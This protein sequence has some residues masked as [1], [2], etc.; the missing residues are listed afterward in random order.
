MQVYAD[1]LGYIVKALRLHVIGG[2]VVGTQPFVAA[3]RKNFIEAL[4]Q[5][6]LLGYPFQPC[7]GIV[8]IDKMPVLRL[9]TIHVNLNYAKSQWTV[10]KNVDFKINGFFQIHLHQLLIIR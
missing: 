5:K 6:L 2:T 7:Q 9:A 10:V 1:F 3:S 4:A 8:A